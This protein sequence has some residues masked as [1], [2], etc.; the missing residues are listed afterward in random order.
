VPAEAPPARRAPDLVDQPV[1]V[2]PACFARI[3]RWVATRVMA[4]PPIPVD[5]A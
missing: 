5:G 3:D 2:F 4:L 1:E